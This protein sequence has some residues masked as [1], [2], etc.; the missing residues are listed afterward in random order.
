[1]FTVIL[2]QVLGI[3][4]FLSIYIFVFISYLFI[5]VF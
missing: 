5:L 3:L 4:L 2:G 1:M